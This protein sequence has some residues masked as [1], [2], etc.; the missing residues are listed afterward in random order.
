M[1]LAPPDVPVP[2]PDAQLSPE[3][4]SFFS[5]TKNRALGLVASVLVVMFGLIFILKP[6]IWFADDSYFYFQVAW[7]FAR[8][9]GSTFN[10]VM[11]TNGYHPLWMLI[12]AAIFKVFPNRPDTVHAIAGTIVLLDALML[13]TVRR[14]LLLT[15]RDLWAVAFALLVPFSFLTQLG[16][17]GALSGF[18]LALLMLTGYRLMMA[19][20]GSRAVVFNLVAAL[21]VLGRLDNIFIVTFVWISVTLALWTRHRSLQIVTIP[22]YA[23]LWGA[24]LATNHIFFHVWQPISGMLK[25]HSDLNH[26]IGANLPHNA[27]LAFAIIALC[28]IGLGLTRRDFFYRRIELPFAAGVVCHALYITFKMSSETRWTWYYTSWM[29]LAGVMLARLASVLLERRRS[30]AF[31]V[32]AVCLLLLAGLW[33]RGSY[34]H[35]YRM[36]D[37]GSSANFNNAVYAQAGVHRLIAYDQPGRLAYYSDVQVIALDGLMG[38]LKFQNDLATMTPEQYVR[39]NHVDGFLGPANP[40]TQ[41]QYDQ[42]CHKLFLGVVDFHCTPSAAVAGDYDVSG[43]DI[44]SRVPAKLSGTLPLSNDEII[45]TETDRISV[46]KL[47]P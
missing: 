21:T 41:Q 19:P 4:P 14:I 22:I 36:T 32:S 5:E 20:D 13:L 12:C 39:A 23:S 30:L 38:D 16:T 45:W 1:P 25:S 43:V 15:G 31:P 35:G 42:M 18:L 9:M 44:Y 29:L 40:I 47:K 6:D 24:Y 2:S 8:G 17:E 28:V 3:R 33:V 37:R 34:L 10:N 27:Q 46:W 7:N 11:P 26:K